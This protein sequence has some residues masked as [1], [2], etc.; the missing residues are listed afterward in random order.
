MKTAFALLAAS[1]LLPLCSRS[2]AD[3]TGMHPGDVVIGNLTSAGP[4]HAGI[5]IGRWCLLPQDLQKTYAK[6]LG[7]AD[8]RGGS[9]QLLDSY[10]VIDSMPGRGARVTPFVEQFTDLHGGTNARF[11]NLIKYDLPGAIRWENNKGAAIRWK[12]LPDND[13]RRWKIVEKAL[14]LAYAH[15]PYDD[16]HGQLAT[17][18]MGEA[19]RRLSQGTLQLDCIAMCHYAYWQGAGIDL[20]VSFWPVHSPGQL[21][22]HAV[23]NGLR[24]VPN[25]LPVLLDAAY[26]GLWKPEKVT[27]SAKGESRAWEEAVREEFGALPEGTRFEVR[28]LDHSFTFSVQEMRGSKV[29]GDPTLLKLAKPDQNAREASIL[30]PSF[31]ERTEGGRSLKMIFTPISADRATMTLHS[32]GLGREMTNTVT[33]VRER[34]KT[35]VAR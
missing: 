31:V 13:P 17:T 33:L 4:G 8:V 34:H 26:L 3:A 14:Q 32:V 35:A 20:D 24:R 7:E 12:S 10:L 28:R 30:R 11:P 29:K 6:A 18:A 27:V 1:A 5:Y 19:V 22:E 15:V 23:E 21:Y 25:L 16:K 9:S 2:A